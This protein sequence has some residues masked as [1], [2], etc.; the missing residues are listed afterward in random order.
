M[1]SNFE[2]NDA[3]EDLLLDRFVAADEARFRGDT[4]WAAS[5]LVDL[6]RPA[7]DRLNGMLECLN[8]L[9]TAGHSEAR[10]KSRDLTMPLADSQRTD[11][12]GVA[13]QEVPKEY[14]GYQIEHQLGRGGFGVVYR[15]RSE[16]LGRTAAIK[17][18]LSHVIASD[19]AL[20]RFE[21]EARAS[22][23]LQHPNIVIVHEASTGSQPAIVY[24]Y[25]DGGTLASFVRAHSRPLP[26]SLILDITIHI[27]GA[28]RHA[29]SHG[30]LHRDLKPA[31]ILLKR[32]KTEDRANGFCMG[33]DC[34]VPKLC[35]FGLARI[36]D[37]A[38]DAT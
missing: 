1:S 24:E 26:E 18:P 13:E 2:N 38:S 33:D 17:I 8:V 22:A 32:A 31:N 16:K 28:L 19:S 12:G 5:S 4:D 7:Y 30:V 36:V 23:A 9:A 11:A 29:H 21:V 35:D 10:K 6:P 37:E 20:R 27:A 14:A 15:A 25:C 34:W 3:H